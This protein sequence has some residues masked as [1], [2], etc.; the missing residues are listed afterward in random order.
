MPLASSVAVRDHEGVNQSPDEH[1]APLDFLEARTINARSTLPDGRRRVITHMEIWRSRVVIRWV[2]ES[3]DDWSEHI[4]QPSWRE[5]WSVKDDLGTKYETHLGSSGGTPRK[6]DG[7]LVFR[8][9]P[10][11]EASVLVLQAPDGQASEIAWEAD[12]NVAG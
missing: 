3:P 10:P 9:P 7:A 12:R 11:D 8:P 4:R 6:L 2:E 5:C 1:E